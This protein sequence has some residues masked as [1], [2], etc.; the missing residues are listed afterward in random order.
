MADQ[1][2]DR[3]IRVPESGDAR[4]DFLSPWALLL[5]L[6]FFAAGAVLVATRHWRR[7]SVMIGGSMVLAAVLRLLLPERLAGLL[8]VRSMVFDVAWCAGAGVAVMVLGLVVPGT[9]E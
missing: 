8:V 6:A 2:E 9:F 1:Q 7:G 4:P 5:V 3:V